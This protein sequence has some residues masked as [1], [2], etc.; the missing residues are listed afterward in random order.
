MVVLLLSSN[1]SVFVVIVIVVVVHVV[2]KTILLQWLGVCQ[3]VVG[4]C[5][6]F[7]CSCLFVCRMVGGWLLLLLLLHCIKLCMLFLDLF[8]SVIDASCYISF[9]VVSLTLVVDNYWLL[10]LLDVLK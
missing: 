6:C 9:V 8:L 10:L 2:R 5:C 3:F 1:C 4:F 7:Y